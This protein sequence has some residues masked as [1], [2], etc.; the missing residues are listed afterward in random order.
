M[1]QKTAVVTGSTKG[2]GRGYAKEFL[3]RGVNVVISGRSQD[4]IDDAV[5]ALKSEAKDGARVAGV[6]CEVSDAIQVQ[7][8]WDFAVQGF[9]AVDI[10]INNAGFAR[11]GATFQQLTPDEIKTMIHS[12]VVG[13]IN[14]CQVALRG[15]TTQGH[16]HIYNTYGAGSDGRVIPG[17][18]GYGTTKSTVRYFTESIIKEL[19]GRAI[20]VGMI[21][22]G[23]NLTENMI[24]QMKQVPPSVRPKVMKP[25][26]LLGDYVETTTPWIVDQVLADDAMGTHIKWLTTAKI[27]R[28]L[29]MSRFN[30]RDLW[31][32]YDLNA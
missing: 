31:A 22:P 25:I 8:L 19:K 12:N 3:N 28:R 10:W 15:M 24:A 9:E 4:I 7:V 29:F 32:R 23:M 13:T 6:V 16:G 21:S 14:G 1:A 18:I 17:M 27:L 30:K 5:K 26:N 20:K 11:T 2:I